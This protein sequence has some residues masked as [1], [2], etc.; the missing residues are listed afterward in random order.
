MRQTDFLTGQPRPARRLARRELVQPER[1]AGRLDRTI[2]AAWCACW[3]PCRREDPLAPPNHHVLMMFHAGTDA[4]AVHHC[5]TLAR[6]IA[7]RLFVNTAAEQPA[8]T[9]I[10]DLDGPPPPADGIVELEGRSLV[11]YVARDEP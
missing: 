2:R 1:R 11:C 4:A 9:S 7:W 3:R 5:R 8:T 10:P 6:G